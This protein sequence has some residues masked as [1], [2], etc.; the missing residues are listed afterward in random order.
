MQLLID[1]TQETPASLRFIA[2]TLCALAD[3]YGPP[4]AEH[5]D[6][7]QPSINGKPEPIVLHSTTHML[8]DAS[9][10]E[11]RVT[12]L[13]PA[14]VFGMPKEF[15]PAGTPEGFSP[16]SG[17]NAAPPAPANLTASA[18]PAPPMIP[19][20]ALPAMTTVV[21]IAP[22]PP[23]VG[24]AVGVAAPVAANTTAT[25]DTGK[26]T[27]V[28]LDRDKAGLPWDARI[29][30]ETRKQNADG[31]WR[32]RRNLDEGTKARVMAEL[33]AQTSLFPTPPPAPG[34][35]TAEQIS[36]AIGVAPT[37]PSVTL[38]QPGPGL[39]QVVASLPLSAGVPMGVPNAPQP[40]VVPVTGFRDFMSKVNKALVA[41]TLKQEQ[42]TNACR[43][44]GL[45]SITALAGEP[46]KIPLVDA[47]IN[48]LLGA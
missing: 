48:Q 33:K 43:A 27:A 14:A 1:S 12:G 21:A 35:P 44:I 37:P 10:T 15:V 16:P 41:G 9:V 22:N 8:G 24:N 47:Q 18:P 19:P 34:T 40:P 11:T 30:S 2:A 26:A 13:D 45:D 32:L 39:Q 6:T 28:S 4:I 7:I 25:T 38:P 23:L 36:I 31:T 29:H 17:M 20:S 46:M 5:P 42:L 3:T